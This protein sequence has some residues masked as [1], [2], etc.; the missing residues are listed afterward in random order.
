M[1]ALNILILI[2]SL[3]IPKITVAAIFCHGPE[4]SR[5]E[6]IA[7]KVCQKAR[8]NTSKLKLKNIFN[9]IC[10]GNHKVDVYTDHTKF[11]CEKRNRFG[12][13]IKDVSPTESTYR[14]E[15]ASKGL[16]GGIFS[17][18]Y[19]SP[20]NFTP[21]GGCYS[22]TTPSAT[23]R[24]E[25]D[26]GILA[27]ELA[28]AADFEVGWAYGSAYE[29]VTGTSFTCGV[30][31]KSEA[32]AVAVANQ[33]RSNCD[34]NCCYRYHYQGCTLPAP[35][36]DPSKIDCDCLRPDVVFVYSLRLVEPH[37]TALL[38]LGGS[39]TVL[40][41]LANQTT[42][43]SGSLPA[44]DFEGEGYYNIDVN[45]GYIT[46][47]LKVTGVSLSSNA[48][49]A[50]GLNMSFHVDI[51]AASGTGRNI[52]ISHSTNGETSQ[53][54]TGFGIADNNLLTSTASWPGASL[55]ITSSSAQLD[56]QR[57]LVDHTSSILYDGF[58]ASR[59]WPITALSGTPFDNIQYTKVAS[60][61]ASIGINAS[62]S[63]RGSGT[64]S[65][66]GGIS[67]DSPTVNTNCL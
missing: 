10:W 50:D 64:S 58:S 32:F 23:S 6:I 65:I 14:G 46:Y 60:Y 17:K 7:D 66:S 24:D 15:W 54:L 57:S 33:I 3:L 38:L 27:H 61:S 18:I 30:Q 40:E 42:S 49:L 11:T 35:I 16:T 62:A 21:V 22:P 52:R 43:I 56:N 44:N 26:I 31:P 63:S 1:M 20:S 59:G 45:R 19:W 4:K 25:T 13:C 51:Y 37:N 55:A 47:D 48:F 34:G 9:S 67:V 36:Y 28:H 29:T 12:K 5:C 8:D 2:L 39:S 41:D 53:E